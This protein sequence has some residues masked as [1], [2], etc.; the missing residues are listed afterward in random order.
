[1]I[2]RVQWACNP[3]ILINAS[4]KTG[5]WWNQTHQHYG[6]VTWKVGVQSDDL[7]NEPIKNRVVMRTN[8]SCYNT[9]MVKWGV[10][11]ACNTMILIIDLL[12]KGDDAITHIISGHRDGGVAWTV[13]VQ[14]NAS[15]RW[16]K[17]EKLNLIFFKPPMWKGLWPVNDDLQ[18]LYGPW[19]IIVAVG[20]EIKLEMST[21]WW[22]SDMFWSLDGDRREE[23]I[24]INVQCSQVN[25]F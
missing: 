10:Y 8:T 3:M 1:M 9:T 4:N 20:A 15:G 12:K 14:S 19:P 2:R 23:S 25:I 6:D 21:S 13:A 16:F 17:L 24:G 22:F 18:M 7:I 11:L 5:W